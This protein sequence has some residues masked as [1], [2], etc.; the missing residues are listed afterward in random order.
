MH[1]GTAVALPHQCCTPSDTRKHS[2]CI[3]VSVL[4]ALCK[5][6]TKCHRASGAEAEKVPSA[7]PA[8]KALHEF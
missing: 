5:W 1:A 2:S 6:L 7:A 3:A 8:P 4:Q